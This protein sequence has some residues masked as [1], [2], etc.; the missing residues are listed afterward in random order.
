MSLQACSED[1]SCAF[2]HLILASPV[3]RI[4][5]FAFFVNLK[6]VTT[7]HHVFEEA[8]VDQDEVNP[9]FVPS[10]LVGDCLRLP[11]VEERV[12]YREIQ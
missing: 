9:G 3:V 1:C 5:A 11:F 2:H 8:L 7:V 10:R 6:S 4:F 12:Q